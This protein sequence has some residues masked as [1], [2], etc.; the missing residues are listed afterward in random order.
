[1]VWRRILTCLGIFLA[2]CGGE[3]PAPR[4]VGVDIQFRLG[5]TGTDPLDGVDRLR[6]TATPESAGK[7]GVAEFRLPPPSRHFR[8]SLPVPAGP[9]RLLLECLRGDQVLSRGRSP[10]VNADGVDSLL[11]PMVLGR[12]GEST[13]MAQLPRPVW[14][15]AAVATPSGKVF[16]FGG[17]ESGKSSFEF[18]GLLGR[19]QVYNHWTGTVCAQGEGDCPPAPPSLWRG[20]FT[21]TR[22]PNG[23]V[24]VAGG[25]NE[26][27]QPAME[28]V[29]FTPETEQFET[30]AAPVHVAA[31]AAIVLPDGKILIVGGRRWDGA[32]W[33]ISNRVGVL[34]LNPPAYEEAPELLFEPRLFANL[35]P[36]PDGSVLIAGG[37]DELGKPV[38]GLER[39]RPGQVEQLNAGEAAAIWQD[40]R[41]GGV[42]T[43]AAGSFWLI[44]GGYDG[45]Q[46]QA[47]GVAWDYGARTPQFRN[48]RLTR[49]ET[50]AIEG[51]I[52]RHQHLGWMLEDG[53]LLLMGGRRTLPNG[54][55]GF[56]QSI[57][58]ITAIG[59]DRNTV[60]GT[61]VRAGNMSGRA[62]FAVAG[63]P[64]G[65]LAMIGGYREVEGRPV[66]AP[67]IEMYTP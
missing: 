32:A 19:L 60:V 7:T 52:P 64:D 21:A 63:L 49:P 65:N 5:K 54:S 41:T 31:H 8:V 46:S 25:V 61:V 58:R 30:A 48:V 20:L 23:Q 9:F 56:V 12:V 50:P 38:R 55:S 36:M 29:L 67:E 57:E 44:L 53:S 39:W 22:L 10:M 40:G 28:T 27:G 6:F 33:K 2:A 16:V 11:V 66:P 45:K 1:M 17:A 13:Q 42:S 43:L 15:A 51:T 34:S 62:L 4:T 35:A 24:V 59:L 14:G 18:E 3:P 26:K 37:E 47:G